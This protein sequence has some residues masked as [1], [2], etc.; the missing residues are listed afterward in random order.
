MSL[1]NRPVNQATH[2]GQYT[3]MQPQQGVLKTTSHLQPTAVDVLDKPV[4]RSCW[5]REHVIFNI[6]KD[7]EFG[8]AGDIRPA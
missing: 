2:E 5:V 1:I 6:V 4:W 8:E 7:A 3:P